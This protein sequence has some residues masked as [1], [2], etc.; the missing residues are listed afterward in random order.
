MKRNLIVIFLILGCYGAALAAEPAVSPQRIVSLA[1]ST[2]EILFALGLGDRIVGVT[3]FCDYPEDA[4]KK[5]KIGGMSN[6]SLEAVVTMKPDLVVMTTDGNPKEFEARLRSLKIRTYVF[7]AR[8]LA[9]LPQGIRDMGAFVGAQERSDRLAQE[10]QDGLDRFKTRKS[11]IRKKQAPSPFFPLPPGER[12]GGEGNYHAQSA[13]KK[14]LFI[15]WPEPLIVAGPGTVMDDAIALLGYE[16]IA[17]AAKTSYPK[18]SIEEVIRRAPDVIF[19]GKA[20]GMDIRDVSQ[21]ILK[22]LASVPAVRNG[23]IYYISDNLYR[24][25]PRVIKGIE[26][27]AACEQ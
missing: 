5:P 20:S 11:E 9:E 24:L 12:G 14:V 27:L 1:P 10:I 7:T 3:S 23:S 19:V 25:G 13:M 21:K 2:T 15:V 4:K 26:E 18:Y 17:A 8:R 22:R 6:P 16:N